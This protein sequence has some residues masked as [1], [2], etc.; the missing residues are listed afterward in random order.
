M[1]TAN[2]DPRLNALEVRSEAL[3]TVFAA[4]TDKLPTARVR[5]QFKRLWPRRL[6]PPSSQDSADVTALLL[7]TLV[8]ARDPKG[9]TAFDRL[10]RKQAFALGSIEA[11]GLDLTCQA[12]F[13]VLEVVESRPGAPIQVRDLVAD[14]RAF[15]EPCTVVNGE[16]IAGHFAGLADGTRAT[17][18]GMVRLGDG[19]WPTAAAQIAGARGGVLRNPE[20]AAEAIYASVMAA[21]VDAGVP[22]AESFVEMLSQESGPTANVSFSDGTW[23][24]APDAP[25][26]LRE[27]LGLAE[28]WARLDSPKPERADPEGARWLRQEAQPDDAY[29]LAALGD[30]VPDDSA[31]ARALAA[32]TRVVLDT[33]ER[34]AALGLGPGMAAFEADLSAPGEGLTPSAW[35]RLERLR[36]RGI[37]G[38]AGA[39]DTTLARVIQRIRALQA[40]TQ[41]AGCTE[42]EAMAAAAKAEELLRRYDVQLTPAQIAESECTSARI[43]TPRKRQDALDTC[44][45]AVA[46]F[47]GCRRWLQQEADDRLSHIFFGL[48]ADVVA[49][50]TLFHVIAETFEVETATFKAG[51]TY[52][53]TP[54]GQRAQATK[55][56]RFGLARGIGDKLAEL[57]T[58]RGRHTQA[59]TGRDLV[60]LKA[61]AIDDALERLGLAFQSTRRR[62]RTVDP[63]AYHQG[64]ASGR[65]FQPEPG[66]AGSTNAP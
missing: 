34:R 16:R 53:T 4:A 30:H 3:A 46:Q 23:S 59:T 8:F 48:P 24:L 56:F 33:V 29:T 38:D 60:P 22:L 5:A 54:S 50:E 15:L 6:G 47:C 31:Q 51:K 9:R 10:A 52:A 28:T 65:T 17:V 61:Q 13:Q 57:E 49:A 14:Q 37:G 21:A 63:Q 26:Y 44:A 1:T 2:A 25:D 42:A 62:R 58:E 40:K 55:S 64:V 20:R 12:R 27:L 11:A 66:I 41:A 18:G 43:A 19:S 32:M 36:A 35:Q 7:E 45:S 39:Q